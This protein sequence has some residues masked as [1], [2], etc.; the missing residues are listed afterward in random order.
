MIECQC[1]FA[2]VPQHYIE[3]PSCGAKL[4]FK[5]KVTFKT[6]LHDKQEDLADH[7]EEENCREAYKEALQSHREEN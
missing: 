4:D 6:T 7:T 2:L 5:H 3:C 1:C